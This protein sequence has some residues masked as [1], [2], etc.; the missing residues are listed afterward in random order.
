MDKCKIEKLIRMIKYNNITK[1]VDDFHFMNNFILNI[2]IHH[3]SSQKRHQN[4][5][6]IS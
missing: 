1:I 3:S 4:I 5:N 2:K 6:L